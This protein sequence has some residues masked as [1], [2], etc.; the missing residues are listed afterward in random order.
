M[1]RGLVPR[2]P[3]PLSCCANMARAATPPSARPPPRWRGPSCRIVGDAVAPGIRQA[4]L[5]REGD[6]AAE[7]VRGREARPLADQHHHR[8]R[9]QPA[10]ATGS[11]SATRAWVATTIGA[12]SS[13]PASPAPPA[14]PAAG[15]RALRGDRRRGEPSRDDDGEV[16]ARPASSEDGVAIGMERAALVR[17]AQVFR[18]VGDVERTSTDA[19]PCAVRASRIAAG[20]RGVHTASRA[21]ARSR[22]KAREAAVSSRRRGRRRDPRLGEGAQVPQGG[23]AGSC[24]LPRQEAGGLREGAGSSPAPPRRYPRASV[25]PTFTEPRLEFRGGRPAEG[26]PREDGIVWERDW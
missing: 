19:S 22:P 5:R 13:R 15:H 21:R 24:G 9:L 8:P 3:T 4:G 23:R 6:V 20:S 1:Q 10:R 16:E 17:A 25:T 14:P 12:R 2:S 11:P 7:A 18:P 26:L